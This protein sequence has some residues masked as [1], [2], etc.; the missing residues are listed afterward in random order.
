MAGASPPAAPAV[1][2]FATL[3]TMCSWFESC[4]FCTLRKSKKCLGGASREPSRKASAA[5][6]A[7]RTSPAPALPAV[8]IRTW[9]YP[10]LCRPSFCS[11]DASLSSDTTTLSPSPLA[12][13]AVS[14]LEGVEAHS[15]LAGAGACEDDDDD[16]RRI[17]SSGLAENRHSSSS[18]R[19][20]SGSL[21]ASAMR[22]SGSSSSLAADDLSHP[23]RTASLPSPS[24]LS[25]PPPCSEN[26]ASTTRSAVAR[27][28]KHR[29][30]PLGC[31]RHREDGRM[32]SR[33]PFP[34]LEAAPP[35]EK[36]A[37]GVDARCAA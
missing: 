27:P 8:H 16:P 29:G 12:S 21:G 20:P 5:S 4:F 28:L 32:A 13:W 11:S 26:F 3:M 22:A 37:G 24:D 14:P 10:S 7:S 33:V 6:M 36:H 23:A 17:L 34:P 19:L 18:L 31:H 9:E 2:L 15:N 1:L 35:R 30:C 25:R